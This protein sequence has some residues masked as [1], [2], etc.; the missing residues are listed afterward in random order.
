M[1]SANITRLLKDRP[2]GRKQS[3]DE[4]MPLVYGQLQNIAHQRMLRE[5]AGHTLNTTDLVHEAYLKLG[6]FDGIDWQNRAHFFAFASQVMRNILVD[7][8]LTKKAEKRGGGRHRVTLGEADA[9]TE[10]DLDELISIH[11]ALEKLA[12]IDARRAR[13][14]ECRYFGGLSIEETAQALDISERTTHRD[15]NL[16][17]AWLK[18]ELKEQRNV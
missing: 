12:K 17:C 8:A 3:I 11:Q 2:A 14:V 18:R 13:V 5:N 10:I 7:Y 15:W 6:K 16:A 9:V 1:E 4:L